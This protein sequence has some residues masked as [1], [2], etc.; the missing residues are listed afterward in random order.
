[1]LTLTFSSQNH[2]HFQETSQLITSASGGFF[3]TPPKFIRD[4]AWPGDYQILPNPQTFKYTPSFLIFFAPFLALKY[5]D[6]LVSFDILQVALIPAL[7]FFVYKMVKDRN[8]NLAMVVA[9]IV[10]LMPLPT[11]P[12]SQTTISPF[13]SS[14]AS[15]NAQSFVPTYMIGYDVVNAHVL[16]TILLVGALYF[17]FAKKPWASALMLTLGV[18][19]PRTAIFAFPLLLWY[20]RQ[21]LRKFIVCAV[22]FL[23]ITNLPFF[24]YSS[25][26]L[27]F[28]QTE[29]TGSI[30]SQM[31]PYDWLPLYTIAALMVFEI[32]TYS[33]KTQTIDIPA[34]CK[35]KQ[36]V[37][38]LLASP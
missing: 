10:L 33:G 24:F 36:T 17:G 27:S 13:Y 1:M 15:I 37:K 6:A 28:L 18:F 3:I 7:A 5:Q 34:T 16:Q 2:P 22:V 31:Y 23:G 21:N 26:G 32:L 11:P 4:A 30:V 25:I 9:V 12:L 19:D 14:F 29:I 8:L 20:N 35:K 38:A